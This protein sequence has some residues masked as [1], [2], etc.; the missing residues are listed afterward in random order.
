[1]TTILVV[2]P[3]DFPL[4]HIEER[5]D[6]LVGPASADRSPSATNVTDPLLIH[7]TSGTTGRPKG[8]LH[9][10]EALIGHAATARL[11]LDLNPG[12]V[13]W[14]TADPGWVTGTSY[15]I[16]GP[17]ALG[18]G[19]VVFSG[20]FASD[21]WYRTIQEEG[22]TNWYT[23]PTALRMLMREGTTMARRFDLSSL[24][25]IC[26][27]GEPLNPAVI[28]WG[29]EAFSLTIHDTW[30]QT[31]TG[32]MQI[33]NRPGLPVKAGSM[34]KPLEG[35]QAAILNADTLEV[36]QPGSEGLLALRYPWPSMF[37]TYWAREELYASRFRNGWYLS[38]DR[39][40][41]DQDGYYWFIARDDDVINTSGH[42]VG[43]FEIESALLT[44]GGVAEAAAFGVPD[45]AA[46]ERVVVKVVLREGIAASKEIERHLRT[47]VRRSVG[48]YAV[49][50]E[51]IFELKLPRTRSGKIMR[52]VAKA[53]FLGLPIGDV[54]G[55]ED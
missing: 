15:G 4:G 52:R 47:A 51:I 32:C 18:I 40:R 30:W 55:L 25:H 27:V 37:R 49:P 1:L 5:W 2:G 28:E 24:R 31:E 16:F 29:R 11:V 54:S 21:A 20:G 13:Y 23:S 36:L 6:T 10:Q 43:P 39:A 19:V 48:P 42:L 50:R 33:V 7:Y 12:D 22:V 3:V 8:A 38:G 35:V 45:L 14:C 34:G 53:Q 17:L 44:N 26:S 46:G 9:V 41:C